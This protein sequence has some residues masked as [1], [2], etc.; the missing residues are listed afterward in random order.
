M[1]NRQFHLGGEITDNYR[2]G[3][4]DVPRMEKGG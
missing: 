3:Q 1:I 4:V 2:D